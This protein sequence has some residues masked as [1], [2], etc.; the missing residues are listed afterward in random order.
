[1]DTYITEYSEKDRPGITIYCLAFQAGVAITLRLQLYVPG[2]S[3]LQLN[4]IALCRQKDNSF[5]TLT[6]KY[7]LTRS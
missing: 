1:M 6:A 2:I 7:K 3:M 5:Y 4:L